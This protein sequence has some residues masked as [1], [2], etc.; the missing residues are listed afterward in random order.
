[1]LDSKVHLNT[2][3]SAITSRRGKS[4]Q[5]PKYQNNRP[6]YITLTDFM[7]IQNEINPINAEY[8]NRKAYEE[9]LKKLS[10]AKYKNWADSLEMKKKELI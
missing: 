3:G 5:A 1:M 10:L 6:T 4:H 2:Y 9:K 8:E 7:R